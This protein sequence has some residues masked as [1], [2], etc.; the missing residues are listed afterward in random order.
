M[1]YDDW[2]LMT[3]EE[4]FG[5][6]DEEYC[7]EC[8]L[9]KSECDCDEWTEADEWDLRNDMVRDEQVNNSK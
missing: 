4:A 9:F 6:E 2:K 3:P 8:E 7:E 1:N 5:V